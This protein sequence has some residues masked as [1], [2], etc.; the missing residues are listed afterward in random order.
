MRN[1]KKVSANGMVQATALLANGLPAPDGIPFNLTVTWGAGGSATYTGVSSGGVVSFQLALPETAYDER[2]TFVASHPVD[3]R[4]M[5]ATSRLRLNIEEPGPTPCSRAQQ[6]ERS[7]RRQYK[8]LAYRAKRAHGVR[9]RAALHRRATQA[10][11]RL[12]AAHSRTG[13]LCRR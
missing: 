3:G 1:E 10:K 8:R 11:R 6:L 12:R 9:H 13:A 5:A 2:G 7:L 4:Y